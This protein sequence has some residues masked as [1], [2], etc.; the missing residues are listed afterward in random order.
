MVRLV[1]VSELVFCVGDNVAV[2]ELTRRLA[3][4]L[5]LVAFDVRAAAAAAAA[6]AILAAAAVAQSDMPASRMGRYLAS[7][8][9]AVHA[10]A[11]PRC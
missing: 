3:L 4:A 1:I 7:A 2:D 5:A 11:S 8:Q 6:A 9:I 10:R